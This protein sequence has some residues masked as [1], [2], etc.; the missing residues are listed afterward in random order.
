MLNQFRS[1][2]PQAGLISELITI[3]HGK[4]IVRVLVVVDGVTLASGLAAAE[5]PEQAEDQ[6]RNRA[7]TT[8]NL[9]SESVNNSLNL[10]TK[11]INKTANNSSRSKK[12]EPSNLVNTNI[13]A[14]IS[15][16]LSSLE[17][18]FSDNTAQN[19]TSVEL[20]PKIEDSFSPVSEM[21]ATIPIS[22]GD[23]SDAIAQTDIH[24]KRLGWSREQGRDYLLQTYGKRSR[25]LLSDEE[26]LEFLSYLEN[27]P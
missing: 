5:T 20:V 2:Y 1:L 25:Q 4:Y 15:T 12:Q 19:S 8:L 21:Q 17:N 9:S 3:D 22:T 27:Q 14:S 7:L 11:V 18:S 13:N 24:I 6:A 10:S 26:L 16:S 23:L